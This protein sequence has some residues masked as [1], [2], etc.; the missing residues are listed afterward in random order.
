[1]GHLL[2]IFSFE[3]R[4]SSSSNRRNHQLEAIRLQ[5]RRW[6]PVH[7]GSSPITHQAH[8]GARPQ[9]LVVGSSSC[10]QFQQGSFL[11]RKLRKPRNEREKKQRILFY[12]K[13]A[14]HYGFT[15]FSPHKVEYQNKI[16]P[17]SEHQ[18]RAVPRTSS[19]YC[20]IHPYLLSQ[21]Q[22]CVFG[23]ETF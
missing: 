17:T 16:Y 11:Q 19:K 13:D 7:F 22:R 4:S 5:S 8:Y 12:D 9:I 10:I 15:N 2:S 21:T 3:W 23:S 6:Q 14:P 18:H 1:M 20:G